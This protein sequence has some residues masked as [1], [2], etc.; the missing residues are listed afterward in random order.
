MRQYL[1]QFGYVIGIRMVTPKVHNKIK[2][3]V[4]NNERPMANPYEI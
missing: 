2:I 3:L 1:G 4:S